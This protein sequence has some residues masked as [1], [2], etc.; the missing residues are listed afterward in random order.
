MCGRY[1]KHYSPV[2][3]L[4]FVVSV[5]SS[6]NS[7]TSSIAEVS[8][9]IM[10]VGDAK[11]AESKSRRV[12][13]VN[14]RSVGSEKIETNKTLVGRKSFAREKSTSDPQSHQTD[15]TG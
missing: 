12:C 3:S 2:L 1:T 10:P 9:V 11:E 15:L 7:A 13:K 8:R 6:E 5:W 4:F 14:L